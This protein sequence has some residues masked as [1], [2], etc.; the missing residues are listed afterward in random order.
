MKLKA[1]LQKQKTRI[2][3]CVIMILLIIASLFVLGKG[4]TISPLQQPTFE[5]PMHQM[6][7]LLLGDGSQQ[8]DMDEDQESTEENQGAETEENEEKTGANEDY[9]ASEE[10]SED[11][12]EPEQDE[13]EQDEPNQ[14]EP[15]QD[16]PEQEQPEEQ[17]E[18]QKPDQESDIQNDSSNKD[19]F[20]TDPN[21]PSTGDG[22]YGQEDGIIGEEGGTGSDITIPGGGGSEGGQG[23]IVIGGGEG[24]G[25]NTVDLAMVMKWYKYGTQPKA[26][27]CGPSNVVSADINTV[28]LDNGDLKYDF[29]IAGEE[30]DNCEIVSVS[31]K[32]GDSVYREIGEKGELHINL[33]NATV[34]REYTF[35]VKTI[36]NTTD[37]KGKKVEQ[38]IVYTYV[39]HFAYALDAELEL[40]WQNNDGTSKVVCPANE[41]VAK[42]VESSDLTDNVFIYTPKL[43][44]TLAQDATIIGGEYT[45]SSGDSGILDPDGGSITLKTKGSSDKETYYLIFEAKIKDEDGDVQTVYYYVTIV[46]SQVLD[47][48]LNFVWLERGYTERTLICQPEDVVYIDIK[49]NQLSA[50]AVKYEMSLTGKDSKNTRILSISYTSDA[51]GG[52]RLSASGALPLTIPQGHTSN[53]YKINV[54]AL[55]GGKQI[56]YEIQ[57][58]YSMDVSLE[59]KYQ[60][61]EDGHTIEKTVI[62]ENGKTKNAEPIYDDQL[63]D[64]KLTYVM[65]INGTEALDI[66]SVKC[67]QS[68]S[69]STISLESTDEI[70]MLLNGGK[71]GENAF[72]VL[73]EDNNGRTYQFKINIPYKHHGENNIKIT[74]NLREGQVVTNEAPTN[75]NVR[76][77]S[78]DENGKVV[79]YIPANGTDTKLIVKLDGE[80]LEYVSTSGPASEFIMIPSNPVVGD[81]NNHTLYIYAEDPYGNYGELTINLNGQRSQDGQKKGTATIR[82]DLTSLGIGIVD[83]IEY[84]VLSNEPISYSVVKAILGEDTGAPFGAAPY[85][86][87]WG[88]KYTGTLDTGFYLQRLEPEV[89]AIGLHKSSWRHYGSSEEEILNAID[90]ELGRGSGLATLWRCIYRNGLNK[91]MGT[92]GSYGEF[93]FTSGSGW[94]YSL[95]GTYFPGLSMSEYS[96]EDGDVLTLRYTIASGWEV[97]GGTPGYGKTAGYC[98][99][100][101]DGNFY[102]NHQMEMVDN[103]DGTRSYVCHCCGLE[104]G[105]PHENI[106]EKNMGDGTHVTF[107]NDCQTEIGDPRTHIWET[108]DTAHICSECGASE[109]HNWKEESNTATCTLPGKRV[110]TCRICDMT[111]EEDSP[112]KGHSLN[113]RWNHDK[114]DHYQRCSV[115]TEIIE[116]SKDQHQ[117]YYHEGDDDWYCSICDAGHD[118][119]YCGNGG[120]VVNESTCKKVIY[121]CEEC[122][123]YFTKTGTFDEYHSYVDGYCEHCEA[124]EPAPEPE[125]TPEPELASGEAAVQPGEA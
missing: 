31:V 30:A 38:E 86:L 52:D 79:S 76:A 35:E 32:E 3:I 1:L 64:G 72:T 75:L 58:K 34:G 21:T 70:T 80:I 17:P 121:Y 45:T 117:Y 78:E 71:T 99:T 48:D 14:E 2:S 69:R 39:I 90:E 46:F 6:E 56:N 54:V 19:E 124:A 50:G 95:N 15:Q 94:L 102:I 83:S 110:V 16:N 108:T 37:A 125:P 105:C 106:E 93:D 92:D 26:I 62:C 20:D 109:E 23:D 11:M 22:N 84:D 118:W 113:E 101:L 44:G 12:S 87:G 68:G 82:V 28:H 42:T 4:V 59:M 89:S 100:A 116:E 63:V 91:S 8:D 25:D 107:C 114:H 18:N 7:M 53:T 55:C 57:L 43:V 77:W 81:R 47:V 61:K 73:A 85:S 33:P 115:C 24:D 122:D 104:E 66:K 65:S 51:G 123:L 13:P 27:V 29:E 41:T 9:N 74:T 97:G 40:I 10:D 119:D 103:P 120:L 98:V 111:R 88:G 112:A 36:W 60:V 49:N 67:Y 96:L 5:S